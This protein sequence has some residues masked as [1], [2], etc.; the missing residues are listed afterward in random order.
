MLAYVPF[1][2][3]EYLNILYSTLLISIITGR[4]NST[5]CIFIHAIQVLVKVSQEYILLMPLQWSIE[6][7]DHTYLL[8]KMEEKGSDVCSTVGQRMYPWM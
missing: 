1:A 3:V 7:L 4:Y 8:T 5:I 2:M 6:S